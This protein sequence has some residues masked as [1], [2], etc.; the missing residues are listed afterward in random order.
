MRFF[1]TL[2]FT[3]MMG[4]A[5]AGCGGSATHAPPAEQLPA[6]ASEPGP[7][8]EAE[9][10]SA[11]GPSA[12]DP[13]SEP[14]ANVDSD[15]TD[16]SHIADPPLPPPPPPV[17][18]PALQLPE[19]SGR[20]LRDARGASE[21]AGECCSSSRTCGGLTCARSPYATCARMCLIRCRPDD[22]C[23]PLGGTSGASPPCGADRFCP[24]TPPG[25]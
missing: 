2:R 3:L 14:V 8:G 23:P 12:G 18:R 20:D 19:P 16:P 10:A 5:T 24:V 22:R 15:T 9:P 13:A 4:L 25:A 11:V 1:T 7:A 21:H 6:A 17:T